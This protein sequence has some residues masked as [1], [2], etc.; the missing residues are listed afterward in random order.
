MSDAGVQAEPVEGWVA[1]EIREEF[2]GLRLRFLTVQARPGRSPLVS[3]LQELAR[4][5]AIS[6]LTLTQDGDT[7]VWRRA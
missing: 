6:E 2:P 3:L 4:R 7:V 5:P 1:E